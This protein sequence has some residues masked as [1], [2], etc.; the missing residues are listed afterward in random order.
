MFV[1][2]VEDY[3][4]YVRKKRKPRRSGDNGQMN[5]SMKG[6]TRNSKDGRGQQR[7]KSDDNRGSKDSDCEDGRSHRVQRRTAGS[8][9]SRDEESGSDG[10]DE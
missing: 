8:V 3:Q 7:S 5:R 9:S 4:N 6:R 1:Q 2:E 10:A